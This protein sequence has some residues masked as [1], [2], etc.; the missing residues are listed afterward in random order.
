M[1]GLQDTEGRGDSEVL[2]DLARQIQGVYPELSSRLPRIGAKGRV[3][4][5]FCFVLFFPLTLS[6]LKR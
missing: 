1:A 4:V 2:H 5:L 3:C 6:F